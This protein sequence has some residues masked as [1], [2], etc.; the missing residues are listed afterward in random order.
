VPVVAMNSAMNDRERL[1][2]WLACRDG[3]AAI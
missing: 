3:G 1:D 2:A